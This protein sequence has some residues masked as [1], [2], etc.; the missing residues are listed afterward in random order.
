MF[1]TI[2]RKPDA[3]LVHHEQGSDI[4][5]D[6]QV[7]TELKNDSLQVYVYAYDTPLKYIRLRWNFKE[8]CTGSILSD[9]WER[10]YGDMGWENMHPATSMPWYFYIKDEKTMAGYGVKVRP[11]ALCMWQLDSRGV[12]LW[13][14]VRNGGF[15][16]LLKGRRIK[17]CS[18]VYEQYSLEGKHSFEI[19]QEF[20]KKMCEDPIFP[21]SPVYGANNWYYAYGHSSREEILNDTKY[22]MSMCKDNA[23][24]PFMVIDDCWQLKRSDSYIGGPWISNDKFGDMKSLI[25]QIKEEG[26]RPGIWMRFL[27]DNSEEVPQECRLASGYLDPSHPLVLEHIQEDIERVCSWGIELIKHDFTTFDIFGK[28]GFQMHPT[29]TEDGWHF[30]NRNLTSAEIVVNLYTAILEAAKKT[31]TLILGCNTIGHL[32]A[33][34]MHMNRSGD[35]TSGKLWERSLRMGVNTLAFRLPQHKTFYDI[36]ADCLGIMETLPWKQ[37]RLWAKL[38][39]YSGT[40]LF[41][42]AKPGVLSE[43]EKEELSSY[44]A[45]NSIQTN[46]AIPLDWEETVFP[47]EWK[48]DEEIVSFA[49]DY[50][51]GL[52]GLQ[53]RGKAWDFAF[54]NEITDHLW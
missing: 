50:E 30:Y 9:A 42:S 33:G 35:D 37:N 51:N 28:W 46:K 38:L 41:V 21:T 31:N 10:G 12:S 49:W 27:L 19:A 15:G 16:V 6:V 45:I 8:K 20:C 43:T 44:L 24:P 53:G 52:T 54:L 11:S 3:I 2:L 4:K 39:A 23:N 29:M 1:E 34:L 22:L 13:L 36:D 48:I 14:D 7:Q 25:D 26:A 17:A 18:I 40:S 5:S 32:G 47:E